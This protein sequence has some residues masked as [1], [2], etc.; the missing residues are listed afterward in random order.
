MKHAGA[1]TVPKHRG[2]LQ[3]QIKAWLAKAPVEQL[4]K[5][6]EMLKASQLSSMAERLEKRVREI[7]QQAPNCSLTLI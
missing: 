2:P 6:P 7:E 4:K 1:T 3:H 5:V